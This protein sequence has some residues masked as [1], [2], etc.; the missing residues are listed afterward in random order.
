MPVGFVFPV[1]ESLLFAVEE[2]LVD[3]GT[4]KVRRD[5]PPWLH[6]DLPVCNK[7]SGMVDANDEELSG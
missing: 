4:G 2:L 1:T 3:A 7:S 6:L 5:M